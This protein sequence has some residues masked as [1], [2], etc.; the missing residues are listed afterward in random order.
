[1]ARLTFKKWFEYFKPDE[2]TTTICIDGYTEIVERPEPFW[3]A[4][5]SMPINPGEHYYLVG[6]AVDKLAAY[7]DL[8]EQGLLLKLPFEVGS[9]V[10]ILTKCLNITHNHT[11]YKIESAKVVRYTYNSLKN[12]TIVCL[13]VSA[14]ETYEQHF[15]KY[16]IGKTLF[17]KIEEAEAALQKMQ[18]G[19]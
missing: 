18:E 14:G 9:H 3:N 1:M 2:E 7:E 4:S 17:E 16:D 5:C 6:S 11:F 19:E 8:E 13:R 12:F 15:F 10:Y